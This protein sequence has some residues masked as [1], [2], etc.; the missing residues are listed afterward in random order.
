MIEFKN[1]IIDDDIYYHILFHIKNRDDVCNYNKTDFLK[2]YDRAVEDIICNI[3]CATYYN[4]ARYIVLS[5]F[6]KNRNISII[7]RISKMDTDTFLKHFKDA[8]YK[9]RNEIKSIEEYYYELDNNNVS[10]L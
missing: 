8:C 5:Y 6:D 4:S 10:S 1:I 2:I 3:N 9:L 7:P